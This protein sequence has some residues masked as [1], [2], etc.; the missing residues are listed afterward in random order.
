M[1]DTLYSPHSATITGMSQPSRWTVHMP[2]LMQ[3]L[4]RPLIVCCYL[5]AAQ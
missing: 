2:A 3:Y 5:N 4:C 1:V